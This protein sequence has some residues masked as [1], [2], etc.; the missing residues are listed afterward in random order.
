[1][2]Y[3]Q[4]S[5]PL[6]DVNFTFQRHDNLTPLYIQSLSTFNEIPENGSKTQS[7]G[8]NLTTAHAVKTGSKALEPTHHS[9]VCDKI[10][11]R[12]LVT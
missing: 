7:S 1:M 2:I 10:T 8:L 3:V 6:A 11:T 9:I 5:V 12:S 4:V